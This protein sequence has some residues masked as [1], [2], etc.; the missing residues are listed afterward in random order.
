MKRSSLKNAMPFQSFR[1]S[2]S[3]S[4][5]KKKSNSKKSI[6]FDNYVD[7]VEASRKH[8]KYYKDEDEIITVISIK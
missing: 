6:C 1:Q 8:S 2:A 4:L 5:E 7:V 3:S